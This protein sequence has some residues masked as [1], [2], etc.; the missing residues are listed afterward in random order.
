M[1]AR[2]IGQWFWQGS[3]LRQLKDQLRATPPEIVE[4]RNRARNAYHAAI[5]ILV[6]PKL[7]SVESA[8][9]PALLLLGDSILWSLR[10]HLASLGGSEGDDLSAELLG[11]EPLLREMVP[12]DDERTR[13]VELIATAS[14][15]R[16]DRALEPAPGEVS[17]LRELAD[18]LVERGDASARGV[19]AVWFARLL[20]IVVPVFVCLIAMGVTS[21]LLE[22]ARLNRETMIPWRTS[23]LVARFSCESPRQGCFHDHFFFHT[24][25]QRK[26]WIEFDLENVPSVSQ[27]VI[28]N[29][30]DCEGCSARAVPLVIEVSDDRKKWKEI[31]RRD[32]DFQVWTAK[33]STIHPRWLR[34][35]ST[36]KTSLHLKQVRIQP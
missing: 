30:T 26:P 35:R 1:D 24:R 32:A 34:L 8:Q 14:A 11:S 31:A 17:R 10:A 6:D 29:R 27:L 7:S 2:G 21:A 13:M 4:L 23:S 22:Q 16:K 28:R 36:R 25:E 5:A 19:E 9:A 20:R 12:Q 18:A 33:F 15:E 3:R